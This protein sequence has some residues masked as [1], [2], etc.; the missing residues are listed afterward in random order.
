MD[1]QTPERHSK[2]REKVSWQV[3]VVSILLGVSKPDIYEPDTGLCSTSM[4]D[5]RYQIKCLDSYLDL[6]E[7]SRELVKKTSESLLPL[8]HQVIR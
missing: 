1:Q 5:L 8:L 7:L 2:R 6:C 3:P 4:R